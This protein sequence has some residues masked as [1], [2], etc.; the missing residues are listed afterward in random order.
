MSTVNSKPYFLEN[1]LSPEFVDLLLELEEK[2]VP[3]SIRMSF[4]EITLLKSVQGLGFIIYANKKPVGAATI[5][6]SSE[7]KEYLD[8]V[9]DAPDIHHSKEEYLYIFSVFIE[10]TVY[11]ESRKDQ[12]ID[13]FFKK[14]AKLGH[15]TV[16]THM[17][18]DNPLYVFLPLNKK[19]TERTPVKRKDA[20]PASIVPEGAGMEFIKFRL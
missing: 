12:I 10:S 7:I 20:D 3:E 19:G 6:P 1:N 14:C 5:L 17:N 18:K 13:D 16:G 8:T 15:T 9:Y 2:N 4:E 11:A